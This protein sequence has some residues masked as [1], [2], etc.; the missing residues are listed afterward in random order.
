MLPF[1][2]ALGDPTWFHQNKGKDYKFL[3]KRGVLN[4][5]RAPMF[6]PG[7]TCDSICKGPNACWRYDPYSCAFLSKYYEQLQQLNFNETMEQLENMAARCQ[8]T[9]GF[10][11]EPIVV[12]IVHEAPT[13]LCS[14][15]RMIQKWFHENGVDIQEWSR[16]DK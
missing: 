1:S 9:L 12:L 10:E 2:T 14:E 5:L 11:E 3:D 16:K 4:G 8:H 15:R 7:P 6:M 13:N